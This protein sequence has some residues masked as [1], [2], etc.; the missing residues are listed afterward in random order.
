MARILSN[1]EYAEAPV[2]M[3][4]EGDPWFPI[5]R[6]IRLCRNPLFKDPV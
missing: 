3:V 6:T 5:L 4:G 2:L 1:P